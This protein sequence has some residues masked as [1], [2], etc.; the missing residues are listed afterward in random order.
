M[1][2][3]VEVARLEQ[4]LIGNGAVVTVAGKEV[5]LS[6]LDGTIR[7][8]RWLSSPRPLAGAMTSPPAVRF[9]FQ[10]RGC[11]VSREGCRWKDHGSRRLSAS[12]FR[13]VLDERPAVCTL[14]VPDL[15]GNQVTQKRRVRNCR[16]KVER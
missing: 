1:A 3:Y 5:A 8:G 13:A 15:L 11:Y 7:D 14:C 16:L 4:L 10:D 12:C 9:T 6:N 2:N